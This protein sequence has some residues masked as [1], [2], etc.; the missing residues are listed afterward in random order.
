MQ[1][2]EKTASLLPQDSQEQCSREARR[3]KK[4]LKKLN[5]KTALIWPL[6]QGPFLLLPH[7]LILLLLLLRK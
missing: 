1:K 7:P 4:G 5:R 3:A 6:L 2:E